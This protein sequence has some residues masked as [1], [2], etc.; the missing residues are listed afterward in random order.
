MPTKKTGFIAG[1]CVMSGMVVTSAALWQETVTADI[2][3]V[4]FRQVMKQ[5]QAGASGA[6]K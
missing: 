3:T 1:L 5:L 2:G 4:N 6:G